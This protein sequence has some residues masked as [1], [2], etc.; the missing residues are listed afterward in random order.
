MAVVNGTGKGGKSFQD[1]ALAASVRTL[2]LREIEKVLKKGNGR[3]YEQVLIRL[4]GAILPRLNEVS[5]EDGRPVVI[6]IS[7]VIARK[8]GIVAT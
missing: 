2:A 8:H 5:G 6:E 4:A 7:E 1:R 3:L